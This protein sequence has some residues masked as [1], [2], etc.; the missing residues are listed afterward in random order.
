M[1]EKNWIK[2]SIIDRDFEIF[3]IWGEILAQLANFAK[4][5]VTQP[6]FKILGSGFMQNINNR[7]FL[8]LMH[9]IA[10]D[11]PD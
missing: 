7:K 11:I 9:T 8:A 2:I 10:T 4:M 3:E 5:C 1:Y 6:I